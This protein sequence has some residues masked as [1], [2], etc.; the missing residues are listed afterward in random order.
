MRYWA[1]A[2]EAAGQAEQ[3][4]S[5]D[6][7]AAALDSVVAERAPDTRLR[8]VLTRSSFLL[9]GDQVRRTDHPYTRLTDGSVV[10][11]LPPFAGG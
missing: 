4:V 6:T 8:D 5:A 3:E 2:R 10:E 9:D 7:L 1:A 11:V